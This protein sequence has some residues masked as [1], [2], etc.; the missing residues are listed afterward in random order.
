MHTWN[1]AAV[2]I[3][4]AT[5]IT[6]TP[7][8]YVL[9]TK[10]NNAFYDSSHSSAIFQNLPLSLAIQIGYERQQECCHKLTKTAMQ[11]Q[12]HQCDTDLYDV[13]RDT[14]LF[15]VILKKLIM[16]W[17]PSAAMVLIYSFHRTHHWQTV[18]NIYK[19]NRSETVKA[20]ATDTDKDVIGTLIF[21]CPA[22]FDE[23]IMG[24]LMYRVVSSDCVA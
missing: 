22:F 12:R 14:R 2:L 16:V 19:T 18:G 11:N 1:V 10:K 17:W 21:F 4:Q 8:R 15:R 13:F 5:I 9:P 24:I 20:Q 3:K 7:Q 23:P 6:V